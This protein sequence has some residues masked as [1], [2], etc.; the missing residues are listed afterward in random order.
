VNSQLR[1]FFRFDT[2]NLSEYFKILFCNSDVDI[3]DCLIKNYFFKIK[4][5]PLKRENSGLLSGKVVNTLIRHVGLIKFINLDE[6][7]IQY[8][9][10]LN[11]VIVHSF[12]WVGSTDLL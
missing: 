3:F 10:Y 5:T 1:T 11:K 7:L 9:D 4:L 8:T 6:K 2:L 12:Q